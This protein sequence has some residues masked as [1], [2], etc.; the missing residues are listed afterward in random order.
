[1][2]GNV[3]SIDEKE[4]AII[5]KLQPTLDATALLLSKKRAHHAADFQELLIHHLA[6]N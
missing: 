1:M 2:L 5:W 4:T 6:L 3:A